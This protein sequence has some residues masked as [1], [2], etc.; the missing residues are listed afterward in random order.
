MIDQQK[1]YRVGTVDV[2]IA[3][4]KVLMC[5]D[6]ALFHAKENFLGNIS[7]FIKTSFLFEEISR[8]FGERDAERVFHSVFKKL[9]NTAK[10]KSDNPKKLYPGHGVF[11]KDEFIKD[12]GHGEKHRT[13]SLAEVEN[14]KKKYEAPSYLDRLKKLKPEKEDATVQPPDIHGDIHLMAMTILEKLQ[15]VLLNAI[16]TELMEHK[17]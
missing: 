8:C 2:T 6:S 7:G 17:K 13:Y 4:L 12:F 1:R 3:E 16:Y 9:F 10:G 14:E 15:P 5:F 11:L